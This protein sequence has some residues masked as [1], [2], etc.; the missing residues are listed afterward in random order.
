MIDDNFL[1]KHLVKSVDETSITL[2]KPLLKAIKILIK[3]N[4]YRN[5]DGSIGIDIVRPEQLEIYFLNLD[6]EL[7]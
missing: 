4:T 5:P 3:A 1:K 7:L 2:D 6:K